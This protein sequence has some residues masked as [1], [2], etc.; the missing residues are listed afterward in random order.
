VADRERTGAL[1][2]G[3]TAKVGFAAD[4]RIPSFST[5]Q[6]I[7]SQNFNEIVQ[8]FHYTILNI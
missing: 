8:G 1:T 4:E 6:E 5:I 7:D 3:Q 2:K